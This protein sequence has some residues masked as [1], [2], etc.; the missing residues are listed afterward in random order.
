MLDCNSNQI[1]NS[2][3]PIGNNA[4][5]YINVKIMYYNYFIF[6][7]RITQYIVSNINLEK[8]ARF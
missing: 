5:T 8:C 6:I 7:V 4:A 2:C 1:S 3:R